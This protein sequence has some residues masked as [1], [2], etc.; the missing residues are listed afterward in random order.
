MFFESK[1]RCI[2]G[3]SLFRSLV[4][5]LYFYFFG[6]CGRVA[7]IACRVLVVISEEVL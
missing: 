2:G 5:G 4:L 6:Y 7:L 1:L 3:L